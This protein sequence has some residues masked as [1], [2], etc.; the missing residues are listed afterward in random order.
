MLELNAYDRELITLEPKVLGLYNEMDDL[1]GSCKKLHFNV[2]S[3]TSV[4]NDIEQNVVELENKLSL[5]EWHTLDYKFP[6]DSRFASR[7]DVQRV[8]MYVKVIDF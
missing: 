2:A 7:H 3:M 8:Q 1:S 5:P 4:L 6:L